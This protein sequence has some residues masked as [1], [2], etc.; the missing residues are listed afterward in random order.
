MIG[1]II[2]AIAG[3]KMAENVSG[4]GGAGGAILG[5]GAA[6]LARRLGP[7]GLIAATA[8]GFAVKHLVDKRKARGTADPRA[9]AA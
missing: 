4:I 8:G 1:K 5:V 6:S 2:A 9:R 3:K 7:L